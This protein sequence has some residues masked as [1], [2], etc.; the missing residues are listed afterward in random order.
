MEN[1][2]FILLVRATAP[3]STSYCGT[4]WTKSAE[5][6]RKCEKYVTTKEEQYSLHYVQHLV[7]Y[8]D[9]SV[10]RDINQM[11]RLA[12]VVIQTFKATTDY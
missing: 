9:E 11:Q 6:W 4:G 12:I 3:N 7:R 1:Y 8:F 10:L 2:G 5:I